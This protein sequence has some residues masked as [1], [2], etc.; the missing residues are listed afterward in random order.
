[1]D[2]PDD[3]NPSVT[4]QTRGVMSGWPLCVATR[5]SFRNPSGLFRALGAARA[6]R[7]QARA[8]E[9][10]GWVDWFYQPPLTLLILSFWRDERSVALFGTSASTHVE[11][12]RELI[13]SL[14]MLGDRPEIWSARLKL[15]VQSENAA[16]PTPT[17]RGDD[18]VNR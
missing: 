1:M 5:L 6:I 16:W 3:R 2:R 13:G 12:T 4:E 18:E 7:S 9:G 15:A 14:R 10:F 11:A 17:H 8:V